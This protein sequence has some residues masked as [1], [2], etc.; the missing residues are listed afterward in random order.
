MKYENKSSGSTSG[1]LSDPD[2]RYRREAV[3]A[4]LAYMT[5]LSPTTANRVSSAITTS[6]IMPQRGREDQVEGARI[7]DALFPRR[8]TRT[9]RV[10]VRVPFASTFAVHNYRVIDHKRTVNRDLALALHGHGRF[11]TAQTFLVMLE[12]DADD[13]KFLFG[14]FFGS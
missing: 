2:S 5:K 13:D 8:G 10:K 12:I 1:R 11:A 3:A 7:I 14:S 6:K 9:F 4:E